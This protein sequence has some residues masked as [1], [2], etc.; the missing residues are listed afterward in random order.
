M[1]RKKINEMHGLKKSANVCKTFQNEDKQMMT[2]LY[3]RNDDVVLMMAT[4][5][6]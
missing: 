3:V 5:D 4:A 6:D 2:N 1:N